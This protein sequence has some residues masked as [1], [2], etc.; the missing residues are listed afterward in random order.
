[1]GAMAIYAAAKPRFLYGH[2]TPEPPTERPLQDLA[3]LARHWPVYPALTIW[4]LW[5]FAPGSG[6]ALQFHMQNT[7]HATDAQWGAWNAIF[8]A[9]FIPT[10]LV[11]GMFCRRFSARTLLIWTTA[12]GIPQMVPLYFVQSVDQALWGA[13]IIGL[14]G[15]ACSG[16]FIDLLI[17]SAPKGLQGTIMMAAGS[18]YW[19]AI[20][21][22]D[23]LGTRLYE[24]AG[25][26]AACMVAI[27]VTYACIIPVIMTVPRDLIS[28]REGEA[29]TLD[30]EAE[31]A[32]R[33]GV[34]D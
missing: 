17:R 21:L 18:L 6:T 10:Y 32:A 28:T 27:T 12:V 33:E 8:A 19:L 4:F 3:R 14:T 7:L 24:Q 2:L 23:V 1:M 9:A 11:Y 20:R 22:G 26:F 13:A 16:A 30:T 29:I 25:G 34:R 15:G 31:L 5:S